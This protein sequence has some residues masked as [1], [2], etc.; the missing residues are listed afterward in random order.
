M[1]F[2]RALDAALRGPGPAS[3]AQV[4]ALFR[5]IDWQPGTRNADL[6]GGIHDLGSRYLQAR[7][8]EN[9]VLDPARGP[10]DY[11]RQLARLDRDGAD[12]ATIANTLNVLP[13]RCERLALLRLAL[14]VIRPG[15]ACL[16]W[17]HEGDRSGKGKPSPRTG[18]QCN[19]PTAAYEPEVRSVF[20]NVERH[21][22]AIIAWPEE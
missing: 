14:Q 20:R 18:W 12:S 19:L 11:E 3:L 7:G 15:G 5:R 17:C 9:V 4:P 6:G 1:N 22:K 16:I 13:S 21:G 2:G 10:Q 8:V